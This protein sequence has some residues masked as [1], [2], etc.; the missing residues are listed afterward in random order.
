MLPLRNINR[1]DRGF[2]A[3]RQTAANPPVAPVHTESAPDLSVF[4]AVHSERQSYYG[5]WIHDIP[6]IVSP[7]RDE[8]LR[9]LQSILYACACRYVATYRDWLHLIPYSDAVLETLEYSERYEFRAGTYRPDILLCKD[10][11]IKICEITSRFFGNGYFLTYFYDE[12]ARRKCEHA[13]VSDRASYMEQMLAYF[14]DMAKGK[15]RLVVLKSADRSDSIRLYV[16]FYQALGLETTILEQGQIEDHVSLLE[17][18]FVVSALNQV[19]LSALSVATRHL[20]ADVG[21]RNDFRT[22]YLLHDKRLFR[23]FAEDAF[24]SSFLTSAQTEFLRAHIVPTYLPIADR[25]M[26]E[27]ARYHKDGFIMKHHCLGKSEK[28]YA[29]CLCAADQ[30]DGLFEDGVV[31]HMILQPFQQQRTFPVTWEGQHFDDYV[32][33][34]ILTVDDRY[35]GP[36]IFRASSCPVINQVDDRKFAH[37][38]TAQGSRFR[39]CYYL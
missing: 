4:S 32:C 5:R 2:V 39:R 38:V 6:L 24:T 16:P 35:F 1:E 34:S 3:K 36:G 22:I 29:G 10:G 17:D 12:A 27:Y 30:W 8:E 26:F 33:G 18:A 31:E 15:K 28:V 19:D 7:E 11:S 13:G 25:Q 21:C 37:A 20:M 14:A 23:L 9:T